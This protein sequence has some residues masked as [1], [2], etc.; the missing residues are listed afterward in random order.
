MILFA[1]M[2]IYKFNLLQSII[3]V[4][5]VYFL[6]AIVSTAT[7]PALKL[8]FGD[9]VNATNLT[10]IEQ[11]I[12][13][14][15]GLTFLIV[16]IMLIYLF[17]AKINIPKDL[18]EKRTLTVVTNVV[19]SVFI[20]FPNFIYIQNNMNTRSAPLLIYNS[21]S[22]IL[23]VIINIFN[24]I[25]IGEMEYLKQC[26]EFEKQYTNTL[27]DMLFSLRGFKHDYNNML[28]VIDG[29]I[30]SNDLEGLKKFHSQMMSESRKINNITPLNSYIKDNPAIYGLILSKISFS[31]IMN[32]A[33]NVSVICKVEV[34]SIKIYDLCKVLGILLDNAIEAAAESDKKIAELFIRENA[35]K[36]CLFIEISNSY[37][38][39]IDTESIFDD[40]YTTKKGH[41]GFGLC[42]IKRIIAKYKN[43]KIYTHSL[44]NSFLQR[45]E[46]YY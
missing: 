22:L 16:I 39:T 11:V 43:C 3:T 35:S 25:K 15:L 42:E 19:L 21:I 40:G 26:I 41:T 5:I 37:S 30:L 1:I 12:T 2:Y 10:I 29:Y 46:I 32:V 23:I 9:S 34:S 24:I 13:Q 38:G 36:R 7:L 6:K 27:N 28:Q 33:F 45:I 17:K 8:M 44:Q 14:V 18:S 4:C 20:L 31:E